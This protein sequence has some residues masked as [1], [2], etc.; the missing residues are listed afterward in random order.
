MPVIQFDVLVPDA[1]AG[2]VEAAFGRA[3]EILVRRGLL[4]SA[5]V[6]REDS[7]EVAT[8]VRAQLA[9][10]YAD[11]RGEDPE[12]AGARVHRYLVTA[13]GA[14][15]YNQLAMGLSRILTPKAELPL[16]PVAL[17]QQDRFEQPSIYPWAV[18]ILR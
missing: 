3:L 14:A 7:P 6:D 12:D 2:E 5:G 9:A 16:D 8:S 10:V 1:A 18:E 4:D 17:E 13:D 15:S 11:D